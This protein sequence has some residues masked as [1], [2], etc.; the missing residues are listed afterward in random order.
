MTLGGGGFIIRGMI[1]G[2]MCEFVLCEGVRITGPTEVR[3]WREQLRGE[4]R[5][6]VTLPRVRWMERPLAEGISEEPLT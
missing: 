5:A 2:T 6:K 3:P 1:K 4:V